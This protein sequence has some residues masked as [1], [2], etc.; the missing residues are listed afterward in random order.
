MK[1]ERGRLFGLKAARIGEISGR[2]ASGEAPLFRPAFQNYEK[3]APTFSPG[4]PDHRA[5]SKSRTMIQAF[6]VRAGFAKNRYPLF[7]PAR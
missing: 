3:P 6:D 5:R 1:I 7:R 2:A 4:A